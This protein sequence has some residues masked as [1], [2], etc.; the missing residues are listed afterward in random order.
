MERL[1]VRRQNFAANAALTCNILRVIV[2]V[3]AKTCNGKQFA[4][5]CRH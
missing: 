2:K 4:N 3:N 1:R 5:D